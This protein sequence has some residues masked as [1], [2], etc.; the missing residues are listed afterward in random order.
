MSATA[1]DATERHRL[2]APGEL[3]H[4][5]QRKTWPCPTPSNA[6]AD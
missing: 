4:I 5:H 6:L 3:H 2:A 1:G